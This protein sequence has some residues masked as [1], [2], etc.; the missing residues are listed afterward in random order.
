[1]WRLRRRVNLIL[2]RLRNDALQETGLQVSQHLGQNILFQ[3]SALLYL[4]LGE[5]MCGHITLVLWSTNA[6]FDA[7]KRPCVDAAHD[8]PNPIVSTRLALS[9]P[10]SI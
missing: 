9:L 1:M 2:V 6:H 4:E 8:G 5:D 7:L 10:C 3:R